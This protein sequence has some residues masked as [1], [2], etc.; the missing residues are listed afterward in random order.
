MVCFSLSL[1][2]FINSPK[3]YPWDPTPNLKSSTW[4]SGRGAGKGSEEW[5]EKWN[6]GQ[7]QRPARAPLPVPPP[8]A[9]STAWRSRLSRCKRKTRH[10]S[11]ECQRVTL[12]R[13]P[14]ALA[15]AVGGR[16]AGKTKIN[17]RKT[18]PKLPGPSRRQST[19]AS[20]SASPP[21]TAPGPRCLRELPIARRPASRDAGGVAWRRLASSLGAGALCSRSDCRGDARV[22][23]GFYRSTPATYTTLKW[24]A[25]ILW[26]LKGIKSKHLMLPF[27]NWERN[28]EDRNFDLVFFRLTPSL[29]QW[30]VLCPYTCHGLLA[31]NS[32]L[33]SIFFFSPK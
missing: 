27:H 21:R 23:R 32:G 10:K 19:T 11:E 30:N 9:H 29:I 28:G 5:T 4:G 25:I 31:E 8:S 17:S 22:V 15:E 16:A 13:Q 6:G 33:S 7:C 20:A 3:I 18:A 24:L 26:R 14:F 1:F 2:K 12:L